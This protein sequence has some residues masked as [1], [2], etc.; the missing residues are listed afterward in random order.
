VPNN[1]LGTAHG[2]IRIDY[3]SKG[4]DAAV[5]ALIKMQKQFEAMNDKLGRIEKSLKDTESGLGGVDREL[6]K[7][8]K[9]ARG[10]SNGFFDTHKSISR[11][12]KDTKDL[13]Q[14]LKMMYA[15]MERGK[16]HFEGIRTG[17]RIFNTAG[18]YGR[19]QNFNILRSMIVSLN[20]IKSKSEGTV[21]SINRG[22][23]TVLSWFTKNDRALI[24]L[25]ST[26]ALGATGFINLKNKVMGV[27]S[28]INHAPMWIKK[29]QRL[30][31]TIGGVGVAFG[32]MSKA[33]KPL[34][35]LEKFASSGIFNTMVKGSDKLAIAFTR[36]GGLSKR[37]FG[38]DIFAGMTAS[39][40]RTE[41]N[42]T[43]FLNKT[44]IGSVRLSDRFK[45]VSQKMLQLSK[46]SRSLVGGLALIGSTAK[47][48]WGRLQWFFKLPKPL[49]A[50]FALI[51][52]KVVPVA[53]DKLGKAL[54]ATSN[55]VAGLWDGIKQLTG[56][57]S[58]LPG[59]IASVVVS[60]TSLAA[61][62]IGLG[63]KFKDVFSDDPEKAFEAWM[64]LPAH[65]KPIAK[66][67]K[68]LIPAWKELQ[69]TIQKTAFKDVEKQIQSLSNNYLP[70]LETGIQKVVHS[71]R[72]MKDEL[73][74]FLL[75]TQTKQDVSTVYSETAQAIKNLS[76]AT[77]PA[78]AGM[79]DMTVAG[80]QF[81]TQFTSLAPLLTRHFAS[82]AALNRENGN[83]K[84]W[85]QQSVSGIYDLVKGMKTLTIATYR[86]LT[87]FKTATGAE[88]LQIFADKMQ[89][90]DNIVR[91]SLISGWLASIREGTAK[92]GADKVDEMKSLFR[93]LGDTIKGI[94]P[95]VNNLSESFAGKFILAMRTSLWMVTQFVKLLNEIGA[96]H[97]MGWLLGFFA[98]ARLLPKVFA[99]SISA[100]KGFIGII[101]VLW[102]K[103]KVIDGMSNAFSALAGKLEKMGG[104]WA[105]IGNGM[106]NVS[107]AAEKTIGVMGRLISLITK[108]AVVAGLMYA[109]FESGQEN[110]RNL[111]EA[112]ESSS[113]QLTNFRD[114]L[115]EAF[116]AD[117]GTTGKNVT[118]AITANLDAM[119]TNIESNAE[120]M[121]GVWD[122]LLGYFNVFQDH[123]REG[124]ATDWTSLGGDTVAI[125]DLQ[126]LATQAK[127]AR[128]GFTKLRE[129]GVDLTHVLA[130]GDSEFESWI[131]QQRML[132]H[133]GNA[134]AD[135]MEK[136]RAVLK[137]AEADYR[138]AGPAALQL[139]AGIK[140]IAEAGGDAS[141]ELDGLK[142]VLEAM[143]ILQTTSLDKVQAYE[144]GLRDL[145]EGITDIAEEAG[146]LGRSQLLNGD[147]FNLATQAGSDFYD[148]MKNLGNAFMADSS[149]E[150]PLEAYKR[151]EEQLEGLSR[152][153]NLTIDELKKLA[154]QVGIA[155]NVVELTLQVKDKD[156]AVQDMLAVYLQMQ[157]AVSDGVDI[158]I[159][160]PNL[161][162]VEKFKD[163]LNAIIGRDIASINGQNLVLKPDIS[164]EDLAKVVKELAKAGVNVGGVVGER[165]PLTVPL[166]PEL[167]K[168]K[169][170]RVVGLEDAEPIAPSDLGGLLG[171]TPDNM[172]TA[173]KSAGEKFNEALGEGL[174]NTNLAQKAAERLAEELKEKFHQSPPKSGPLS[175]HGDAIKYAGGKFVEAYAT[176]MTGKAAMATKAA[177]LVAS[178][179]GSGI[180]GAGGIKNDKNYK[181]GKMLGQVSS[182]VN[183]IQAAVEAFSN[184][185]QAVLQFASYISDPLGK[186]TFFGKSVKFRRDPAIS[187]AEL[188]KQ[189]AIDRQTRVS[190]ALANGSRDLSAYDSSTGLRLA[191]PGQLGP[192]ASK[193]QIIAGIIAEGQRRNLKPAQIQGAIAAALVESGAQNLT[194]GPDGSLG[195][196]QEIPAHGSKE[197][198][199]DPTAAIGRFYDRYMPQ[200]TGNEDDWISV[201]EAVAN[202]Q[203]PLESL[204]GKYAESMGKAVEEYNKALS[205]G[206]L[207]PTQSG[208]IMPGGVFGGRSGSIVKD[209]GKATSIPAAQM[210]GNAI[211]AAFPEITEIYGSRDSNTA[212]GTHDVGKSID[213]PIP[214][215]NTPAGKALGDKIR[216]TILSN[217]AAY[218]VEYTIW[219]DFWQPT[220]GKP[221][222]SSYGPKG[223]DPSSRHLDHID[224]HFADGATANIGPGGTNLNVPFGVNGWLPQSAFGPPEEPGQTRVVNPEKKYVLGPD[225]KY[226]EVHDGSGSNPGEKLNIETGK[227]W[228]PEEKKVFF[229]QFPLQ[230][231]FRPE[232]IADPNVIMKT[233]QEMVQE[234]GGQSELLQ[235]IVANGSVTGLSTDQAIGVASELQTMI[236]QQNELGTPESAVKSSFLSS[237]Q[238]SITGEYGLTQEANPIDQAAAIGGSLSSIAGDI[239][240]AINS[241]IES[242]G[243]TKEIADTM[244]RGVQN[245]EDVFNIIDQ[246]QTYFGFIAD[247]AGSVAS[248][249]GGIGAIV[250]AANGAD[251]SGG[252]SGAAT[253][254]AAVSQIAG[255]VQSAWETINALIDIGQEVYRIA[256]SYFGQY[257][258][259]LV[260]G[261][262]GGLMG[263]V[264][265]LLDE[266]IGQLVAYSQD[267]PGDKRYHDLAFQNSDQ[268]AR[269]QLIGN[270]NVY[271]GPGT[272]PRDSTRQMMFQVKAS[273]M[274]QAVGQ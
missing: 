245:T 18:Q 201:G 36:L 181:A 263:N 74:N 220:N 253:A 12:A 131:H 32:L 217:A 133:E 191:G 247:I 1:D 132:G 140:E 34:Q 272:D 162:E 125:N 236:D 107:G 129:A 19:N 28:A 86:V 248:I 38:R 171:I 270:I 250:S 212:A 184:M 200:L 81:I 211:A 35:Y 242:V 47:D 269:N 59:L 135:A 39:L 53:L 148:L 243:A 105:T 258:G 33:M 40:G 274:S 219:N 42:V 67:I 185:G 210:L 160:V 237:V 73:V 228:T 106:V 14:D 158:P 62:F 192:D 112:L 116:T 234:L 97:I 65:L 79:R 84:D 208:L 179:A 266:E 123:M 146:V 118:S 77:G 265:F 152:S 257:L 8:T 124:E 176:G 240:A 174:E 99:T 43:R 214:N 96:T 127:L 17:F 163:R 142:K 264:K 221:G 103:K 70:L 173:G 233:Q 93:I 126:E 143:G 114:A 154:L 229:E 89:Q 44:S 167:Q 51:T 198:R 10:F 180:A 225:G 222:T 101:T 26:V 177:N 60:F 150:G 6:K 209:T 207:T 100:L 49:L 144:Q 238:S 4:S 202:A 252:A 91:E 268:N 186:G 94:T 104:L 87:M 199:L 261:P 85:M 113:K 188:N 204:R 21:R 69:T 5:A 29:L 187:D 224:V 13:T 241:G 182:I 230:Y 172:E 95:F 48:L 23:A 128:D 215:W 115:K 213:I 197:T 121:P 259:M 88:F 260:G 203:K 3:D 92:M 2:R 78:S 63:D 156:K 196:F 138:R 164:S 111:N 153:T 117:A 161:Q 159:E 273:S 66:V 45:N 168:N 120:K 20:E 205:S 130:A 206:V 147:T 235:Q 249:S 165:T 194:Y 24:G 80:V 141:A 149:V 9:A 255:L 22:Q 134:V 226:V 223:N 31:F 183:V 267:N 102:N 136:Q 246:V 254:I 151:F 11:F 54:S 110:V 68:G 137:Q 227:P 109:V 175:E 72:D 90:F 16:R 64:K 122:H 189:R 170:G 50:A 145:K 169:D 41:V 195:V 178:S 75:E 61:V 83:L 27:N 98:A 139:A 119:M 15:M 193:D 231:D 157:T 271:G 37:F 25:R 239:F 262:D 155:P 52:A 46:D 108:V 56:G 58:V 256:G 7:T 190:D 76:R 71:F 232:D 251:P 82:W 244:V 216:N 55:I 30:A 218:G 57:L 166:I